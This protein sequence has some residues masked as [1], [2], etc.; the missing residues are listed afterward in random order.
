MHNKNVVAQLH[1]RHTSTHGRSALFVFIAVILLLGTSALFI[2]WPVV[3]IKVV[4]QIIIREINKTI[5][6]YL[7]AKAVSAN[8]GLVPGK[9]LLN[10]AELR[11]WEESIY[12]I[13]KVNQGQI[14]IAKSDLK[15]IETEYLKEL[16]DGYVVLSYTSE[17][18]QVSPTKKL[19]TH[20]WPIK[21]NINARTILSLPTPNWPERIIGLTL[22]EAE[23]KLALEPGV[24]SIKIK[25]Y[26]YFL[27]NFSQKLQ[28][29]ESKYK[30]TLDI[31]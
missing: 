7:D 27:A 3:E 4:P 30:I 11:P 22:Q 14:I 20:T 31:K 9:L 16:Q 21:L 10:S 26:P 25:F 23:S 28:K 5:V 8:Q 17:M 29:D 12:N 6:I 15:Q 13:F 18:E 2:I 24:E 19:N 1:Y